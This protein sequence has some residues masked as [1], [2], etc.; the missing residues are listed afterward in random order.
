MFAFL[1]AL[2]LIGTATLVARAEDKDKDEENEKVTSLDKIPPAAKDALVKA[3]GDHTIDKVVEGSKDGKTYYEAQYKD[4]DK[5]ME[6]QVDGDGNIVKS[7][8]EEKDEDEN[9]DKEK[10]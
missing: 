3:V 9:K 5:K 2:G 6:V 8:H 1:I 7:P 10:K 4:G